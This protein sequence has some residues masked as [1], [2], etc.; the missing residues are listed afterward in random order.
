[1]GRPTTANAT[2]QT[3]GERMSSSPSHSLSPA[4]HRRRHGRRHSTNKNKERRTS[5]GDSTASYLSISS[6]PGYRLRPVNLTDQDLVSMAHDTKRRINWDS[7][8]RSNDTG[9][10]RWKWLEH[11]GDFTLFVREDA[12]KYAVLAIGIVPGNVAEL[13]HVMHATDNEQYIRK[14]QA[15][16][17]DGFRDGCFVY[18]V[19]MDA[20]ANQELSRTAADPVD[21]STLVGLSVKTATFNKTSWLASHQEW[22]YLD[23]VY[24]HPER[25]G[26]TPGNAT[27][28]K[29]MTSV[30]PK[31]IIAG[32]SASRTKYI[33]H[34][35]SGYLLEPDADMSVGPQETNV[36]QQNQP[37]MTRVHFYSELSKTINQHHIGGLYLPTFSSTAADKIVK[38]RLLSMARCSARLPLI[39]RRRRLGVQSIVDSSRVIPPTNVRCLQCEKFMLVA[40][41]CQL[42]GQGVC[43]SCSHKHYRETQE[44]RGSG[45]R[46]KITHIRVCDIC[47]ERVE[48][49]NFSYLNHTS[50]AAAQVKEDQP[51]AKCASELLKTLL[52]DAYMNAETLDK[53]ASVLTV[54]R[55]VLDLDEAEAAPARS[56]RLNSPGVVPTFDIDDQD[57]ANAL[58]YMEMEQVKHSE[59][60]LAHTSGRGYVVNPHDPHLQMMHP[61]PRNEEKRLKVIED[62]HLREV[63]NL[64]ELNLICD[65]AASELGCFATMVTVIDRDVQLILGANLPHLREVKFPRSDAFCSHIIMDDKPLVVPHPEADVRFHQCGPVQNF[66][67]RFYCGFPI[68]ASNRTVLGSLCCVD[69]KSHELTESQYTT[70]AKLSHTATK[71]VRRATKDLEAHQKAQ[72]RRSKHRQS[73]EAPA[74]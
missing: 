8:L 46:Y 16:Y 73:M 9:P 37:E 14:M 22:C 28:E 55:S 42:C 57:V 65:I 36:G 66:G 53:K 3:D 27:Y 40:K 63:G 58:E 33:E 30:P 67:A 38:K 52:Q 4:H 29:L 71:I 13:V 59:A 49:S 32:L 25:E 34:V 24:Q 74:Y 31:D 64:D 51:N 47:M 48:L 20:E 68:F 15:I 12:H 23:A 26:C 17:G 7:I 45:Y 18:N 60:Q 1:M 35:V 11:T 44:R 43:Q 56:N 54:I 39:I 41:M 10:A 6:T 62:E 61:L 21:E 19:D 50:L 5:S 69:F 2:T 70:L 72:A